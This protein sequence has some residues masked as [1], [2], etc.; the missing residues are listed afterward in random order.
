MKY[1]F[2]NYILR[3]LFKDILI[4]SKIKDNGN[5]VDSLVLAVIRADT[6]FQYNEELMEKFRKL[7][8]SSS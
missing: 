7:E 3:K 4:R 2:H 6:L 8:V 5:I 1:D